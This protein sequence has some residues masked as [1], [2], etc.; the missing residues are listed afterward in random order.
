MLSENEI[1]ILSYLKLKKKANAEEISKELGLPLSSIFSLAKLLEEK[2]YVK[3]GERKIIRFEL[4]E[5]GKKRLKEGFPEEILLKEL[6]GQPS[7]IEDLKNK[8]GKDLEIAISW[9]R[10]KNLVKIDQNRVIPNTSNY[11]FSTEKEALLKP[12][13]A[14]EK[15]LQELLSRKLITR[16]EESKL[17]IT[18]LKEEF[19]EQNYI[20]Q[21]TSELLRSKDW[22]K[23]KIREYNVEAL[24]PYFPLAKKHFFRDFI[25]K[26]KDVMKELGFTEVNAGYIEMELYNFDLLFQAQDHPA[27]EIHDSFRVD[28][29]GKIDD[30]RLLKEI[31]EMHEKGWKYSWDPQ[32]AKRLV[33]RSQTTAV[34]ARILSSRP[35]V[36]FKGFSLGKV[37]RPDSID[38]THLIEFH[39]LDGVIIQKE[40]SF[41]DLLGILREIFYKIG[42]KEIKFKP[43]YFPFT[44]P[45][46][47][48]YGKIEGLGWVEMSG[49]GLLRPEI[50]KAMDIDANAG[51]WG[52][53]ID[54]LAMLLFGLKDI[55]LL[56]ANDIDFLRKM[57][58]RL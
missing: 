45:S 57:K 12:E 44:E 15:V 40:F 30:E 21:L 25:E 58:V 16:K 10:K 50:L 28:G 17:E 32:I 41:T 56:Y 52:I 23:Y 34:T 5:E 8:M 3:I 13:S 14:D 36:P 51:A 33:L 37:F 24:P 9:A 27:R 39:Q 11:T 4:T 43:G 42:I 20:T 19:E 38:A 1:K 26:L 46:V 31:K 35:S 47:E 53:G 2:G 54:R 7:L 6:N 22:K 55:R 18:L 29:L 48:V 49:A